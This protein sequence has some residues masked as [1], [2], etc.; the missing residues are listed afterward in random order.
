MGLTVMTEGLDPLRKN[1]GLCI[2]GEIE[3]LKDSVTS[4]VLHGSELSWEK[5]MV[6]LFDENY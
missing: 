4:S 3:I 5:R 2:P 6:E 1:R